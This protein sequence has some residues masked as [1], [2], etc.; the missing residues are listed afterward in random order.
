MKRV[1]KSLLGHLYARIYGVKHTKNLYIGLGSKLV[2]G[3][4]NIILSDNVKIMPQAMLVSLGKGIIEIGECTEV[5]MYSRVAS[6][7]HVAIGSHVLMG[8]HVFIADYNHEYR[9][10]GKPVMYQGNAFVASSDGSFSLSIGDDCWIG[11]N[12]VIVGNVCIGKHCVIGANSVVTKDIPD[13]SVAAG[14]PAKVVKRYD[15]ERKEWVR[16]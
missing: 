15:F 7:G 5:S 11:T 14:I 6:V 16:V 12:V 4:G 9:D 1:L 10:P 2:G 3:G 13:Y 8:P